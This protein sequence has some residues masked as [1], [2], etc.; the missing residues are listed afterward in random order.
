MFE[1]I[2]VNFK[3]MWLF[4]ISVI[5]MN[6]WNLIFP[7]VFPIEINL[8][9]RSVYFT[10]YPPGKVGGK[11]DFFWLEAKKWHF[12]KEFFSVFFY[13]KRDKNHVV[14]GFEPLT[15]VL[16]NM[17][18][19]SKENCTYV[20]YVDKFFLLHN[21]GGGKIWALGEGEGKYYFLCRFFSIHPCF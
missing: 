18:R 6:L 2:H 19:N 7:L 9:S 10:Y 3:T 14:W 12:G 15:A 11:H 20:Y 13:E 21:K 8:K 17:H 5:S 4:D 1:F 16:V